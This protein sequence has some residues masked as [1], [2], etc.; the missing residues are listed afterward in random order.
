M[1]NL[2]LSKVKSLSFYEWILLLFP[3]CLVIGPFWV[4]FFLILSSAIFFYELIKRNFYNKLKLKW[5]YFYLI[6]I[7]YSVLHSF[8]A[9]DILNSLQSSFFQ[10]RYLL[11]SLFIF[12]CISDAKN[13]GFITKFW[14]VLVLLVS[15]DVIYQYFFLKNIFG[16]PVIGVSHIIGVRPSGVFGKEL[17]AGAFISYIS[18]PIISYYFKKFNNINLKEK[19]LYSLIYLFLFTTVALTGERL[20]FLIFF[21]SS[22]IIFIFNTNLKKFIILTMTLVIF[23]ITIYF[24]SSS[25]NTRVKDFNN[26]L[27]NFYDSSYG[28]L[29]ESGYLLFEKNK[30]FGVG[31]KNYRV[32][33]DNQIDPRPE[34]IPQFCSTHPHNFILEILS[35]TG[36]VGFFIF[37]I[38]FI[39]LIFYLKNKIR[40]LKSDLI[41]KKY[42]SLLY[43]NI[44]ILFIYVW[45]LKTSGSFFTT[46][47]GSFFWLN[48][49]IALLITKGRIKS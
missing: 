28:R 25:F 5:I 27:V 37:F 44:L 15:F 22:I 48:L 45:P 11:F 38:F 16:L 35:E 7:L 19:T 32:D 23:L 30:I 41:F 21:V 36:L 29:W 1:A 3:L 49:G 47:N 24:N 26:I 42:S 43:G 46:W 20:S 13:I 10:F 18:V 33:C 2:F 8:F 12:L 31:L 9:T 17:I 4:N 6:F 40:Y 34:S 14:L 39:Y